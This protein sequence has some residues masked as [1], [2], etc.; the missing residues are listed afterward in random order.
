M[1]QEGLYMR[2][3]R[4]AY[5]KEGLL[6]TVHR[7]TASGS[8]RILIAGLIVVGTMTVVGQQGR[9]PASGKPA[10]DPDVTPV[11]G[12]SWLNRLGVTYRESMLG[13]GGATYGPPPGER[14]APTPGIP[15]AIGRPVVLS[16]GDLYRLNCQSC[17]RAE[18]TGSPSEIKSVLRL[19]QGS[20]LELVRKRLREQGKRKAESAAR[21]QSAKA[22]TELHDRVQR[23]GQR[24]PP[25]AHLQDAD[26]NAL[27]AY[28][29]QLAGTPDASPQSRRTVSWSRLGE[30]VIKG[31]CHICHDAVGPRPTNEALMRGTIPPFT[32]LLEEKLI[33]QFLTKVRTG[34]P[35]M[36][37][38][39][40]FHYRGRMPV[41]PY[42]SDLE[43]AAAYNF[44][45]DYPPQAAPT[46]R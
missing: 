14:A 25:L 7:R 9:Q 21:A 33:V 27:Y 34:A 29:T 17:H 26:F 22:R 23:G 18:G 45:V 31:T 12:P 15:L 20:S 39:P 36:A 8:S 28:L 40:A 19:V 5:G 2:R 24:M 42:L 13:R 1:P 6:P 41:F 4:H 11:V 44:L 38:D 10:R 35:V 30:H 46:G 37:G 16:G 43:V 3:R 32:T